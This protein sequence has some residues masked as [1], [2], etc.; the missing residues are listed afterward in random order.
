MILLAIGSAKY[1]A[2]RVGAWIEIS[3]IGWTETQKE[4][5]P[6]VGAWIEISRTVSDRRWCV[7]SPPAWGRG[8]KSLAEHKLSGITIV[9]PRVGAWI[10]M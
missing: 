5:A 3:A 1:V 8:L 2:P 4:V 10:E 9:A 7:R 6:R